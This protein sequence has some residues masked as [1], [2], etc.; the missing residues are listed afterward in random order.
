MNQQRPPGIRFSTT[1]I[2]QQP[3]SMDEPVV[4]M[5][6]AGTT[7]RHE[8][9]SPSSRRTRN[10]PGLLTFPSSQDT[11]QCFRPWE[12]AV[13]PEHQLKFRNAH[14]GALSTNVRG[15]MVTYSPIPQH[16]QI[17]SVQVRPTG[18]EKA[19]VPSD[20]DWCEH[21]RARRHHYWTTVER[22]FGMPTMLPTESSRL[23]SGFTA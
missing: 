5:H 7:S 20:S 1:T 3:S 23:A 22:R 17:E 18:N 15:A 9:S 19:K 16:H 12:A 2:N 21:H 10:K 8:S 13:A 11:W 14:F 4:V 6:C